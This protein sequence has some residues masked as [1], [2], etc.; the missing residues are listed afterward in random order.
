[1][2]EIEE[3]T[4]PEISAADIGLGDGHDEPAETEA[5]SEEISADSAATE[6]P[7]PNAPAPVQTRPVPKSWQKDYHG[8]WEKIDPKA[9]EYIELREKQMLDGL[10]QYKG[11]SGFGKQMREVMTPYKAM[12]QAQNIDEPRAVQY[13][14]NAHY[15]LTNSSPEQKKEYFSTLAKS[16]G[17]QLEGLQEQ[18]IDPHLKALQDTV[19]NL[20]SSM[21]AREQASLNEARERVAKDV[22]SFASDPKHPYFD[23]VADD[24]VAMINAGKSLEDAYEKAVWANP[25]TRQKEIARVQTES[26]A[27]LQAKAKAEAEKARKGTSVNVNSRDTRRTP[28]EPKG[29][30]EDTMRATYQEI[31]NRTH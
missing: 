13:L 21:T 12:L 31:R 3:N 7:D 6:I 11:D 24:I 20:R 25:V 19:E 17:I 30:M 27:E 23:E 10:E 14:L 2:D 5:Q 1:M 18:Q 22:E 8:Y 26:K 9:Q 16:Y 15:K 4:L 28:T 29:T